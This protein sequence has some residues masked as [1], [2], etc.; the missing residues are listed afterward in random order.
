MWLQQT[1]ERL[2][3]HQL[4][5]QSYR[6]TAFLSFEADIKYIEII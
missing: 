5:A 4:D 6:E 1:A 3:L 2:T